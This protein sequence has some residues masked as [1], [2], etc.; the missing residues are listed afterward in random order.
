MCLKKRIPEFEVFEV[1]LDRNIYL[2]TTIFINYISKD[3]GGSLYIL[4]L[5]PRSPILIYNLQ[6]MLTILRG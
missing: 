3:A 1:H 4:G 6:R 2:S 5:F